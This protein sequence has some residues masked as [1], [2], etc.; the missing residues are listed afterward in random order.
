MGDEDGRDHQDAKILNTACVVIVTDASSDLLL[1]PLA[2]SLDLSVPQLAPPN[3]I[4][5]PKQTE[6]SFSAYDDGIENTVSQS[7]GLRI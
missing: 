1:G 4:A 5:C 7:G 6:S 2:A 3:S